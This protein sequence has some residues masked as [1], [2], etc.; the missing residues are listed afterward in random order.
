MQTARVIS[1]SMAEYCAII[2]TAT[3][4]REYRKCNLFIYR[5]KMFLVNKGLL[6]ALKDQWKVPT[7]KK[8]E[9]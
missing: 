8:R 9:E 6:L 3:A 4:G 5:R 2:S 1:E 7:E